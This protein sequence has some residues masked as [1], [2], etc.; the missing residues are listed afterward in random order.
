M[1][2]LLNAIAHMLVDAVC[3]A[4]LFG[5]D[6]GKADMV[7]AIMLYNTLA[8]STQCLVGLGTDR[9]GRCKVMEP[10]SMLLV[11][12]GFFLPAGIMLKVVMIGIG[13]SVF[14]VC[15]GSETIVRSGGKAAPLGIF[16]AP[17][18]LGVCIGRLWPQI[19]RSLALFLAVWALWVAY[20]YWSETVTEE[21]AEDELETIPAA[22]AQPVS[23]LSRPNPER[24]TIPIL[25]VALLTAAVAVRAVGG[26]VTDFTWRSTALH[27]VY[28]AL[29]VFAGKTAGGFVCDRAGAAKSS[30]VTVPLAALLTAFCAGS[31]GLSLLGQFLLNL[32]MPV[33]LWLLYKLMPE[34]PGFSFGLAASALWPGTLLG[35]LIKLTG[36]AQK[37]LIIISFLVGLYA[38]MYAVAVLK[39]GEEDL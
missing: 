18:A 17:G 21:T 22:P 8:F 14:H 38:I 24:K 19:G 2:L 12:G 11:A 29:F 37:F 9:F 35:M 5:T 13:N 25:A 32:S 7:A 30:L 34:E 10:L 4:T 6:P 20:E 23:E 36:P 26:S 3:L 33:T 15:G 27:T 1:I 28:I 16:V 31:M 39:K